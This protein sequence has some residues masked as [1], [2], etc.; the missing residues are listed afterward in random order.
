M[1][2]FWKTPQS[3]CDVSIIA[4]VESII[5]HWNVLLWYFSGP[6][7]SVCDLRQQEVIPLKIQSNSRCQD[8]DRDLLRLR[9]RD[10]LLL[11][12]GDRL[13]VFDLRGDREIDRRLYLGDLDR[14]LLLRR[15]DL[16]RLL[17]R[18]REREYDRL[19]DNEKKQFN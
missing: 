11:G 6:L 14:D 1:I 5:F 13:G 12:E 17:D 19:L 2:F 8:L 15:S 10:R 3:I 9:D 18:E 4:F 7:T 16:L